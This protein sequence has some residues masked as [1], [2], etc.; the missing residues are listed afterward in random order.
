M[1][2]LFT[3][4]LFA[5]KKDNFLFFFLCVFL[6]PSYC[7]AFETGNNTANDGFIEVEILENVDGSD[8][9]TTLIPKNTELE[10]GEVRQFCGY[11]SPPR[12]QIKGPRASAWSG[13]ISSYLQIQPGNFF[14]LSRKLFNLKITVFKRPQIC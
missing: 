10:L 2:Y 11:A 6:A 13:N 12:I 8:I 1:P 4:N 9:A 7:I 5:L 14:F 3:S